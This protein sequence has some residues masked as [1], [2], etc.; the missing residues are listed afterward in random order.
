M[1]QPSAVECGPVAKK[2]RTIPRTGSAACTKQTEYTE[3]PSAWT[4]RRPRPL[5]FLHPPLAFLMSAPLQMV[6][7]SAST[8][9][10]SMQ[11]EAA[12]GPS[13]AGQTPT[14]TGKVG[15]QTRQKRVLPARS[16]RGG[17]G[18][19]SCDAD[20]M[21]LDTLKRQRVWSACFYLYLLT[22]QSPPAM[23]GYLRRERASHSCKHTT[24]AHH[25]IVSSAFLV[26]R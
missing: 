6:T 18:I 4:R 16:R 11:P 22:D 17:P 3:A 13:S 15:V 23:D 21:I 1:I 25:K 8:P 19:G 9:A 20:T 12:A 10:R 7:L 14:P 26:R 24:L 5:Y 2:E